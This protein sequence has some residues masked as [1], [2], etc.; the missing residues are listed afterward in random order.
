M[1]GIRKK[2]NRRR[3]CVFVDYEHWYYGYHNNFHMKPNIEEW[4][5]ELKEEFSVTKIYI[6]GDF[7][8]KKMGNDMEKLKKLTPNVIHTASS[9][10]GVDKDF[11]DVIMLD[12]IY[13]STAAKNSEDVYV[14]FTGDAHFIRVVEYLKELKKKVIIYGVK[15]GFSNALKSAATSYVEMP[16]QSQEKNYYYD[17]ILK[18][19]ARLR[20]RPR[21]IVTYWKTVTSVAEYNH[22][23]KDR[24]QHALDDMIRQKFI[25]QNEACGH[26]G[27]VVQQLEVD[28]KRLADEGIW[29]Q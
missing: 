22:V 3:A 29:V 18:S 2:S 7:S 12:Y 25:T 28:W 23:P 24:V 10:D 11:T 15:F 6:F 16:R 19:L 27:H 5:K 9:K 14:I 17:I 4:I 1:F 20:H 8:E 26:K 13:R 21:T